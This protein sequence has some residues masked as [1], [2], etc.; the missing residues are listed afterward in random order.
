MYLGDQVVTVVNASEG[1]TDG[2]GRRSWTALLQPTQ[3]GTHRVQAFN[4]EKP[5]PEVMLHVQAPPTEQESLAADLDFLR[6]LADDTGGKVW[7]PEDA[8]GLARQLIE[9]PPPAVQARLKAQWQ[10]LWPQGWVFTA[11]VS[12]LG[13]EWWARRRRGLV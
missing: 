6:K 4:G 9:S 5:G 13:V 3:P 10:P 11:L 12:L 7:K 8:A 2:E 1:E